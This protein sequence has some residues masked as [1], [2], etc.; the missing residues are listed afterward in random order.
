MCEAPLIKEEAHICIHCK[1]TL[2]RTMSHM[3]MDNS[4][5]KRFWGKIPLK[6]AWAYLKFTKQGKVQ[7]VLHKLKYG[8]YQEVGEKLGR[9]YAAELKEGGFDKEFD[10]IIPVPL[11]ISKLKK[12]G[13][14]QS[15][16]F[17]K[18][19]SEE[20]KIE[21]NQKVLI[22]NTASDTQ[23]KKKRLERWENVEKVFSVMDKD[24]ITG[25]RILLVDDVVTTGSTLEA[26]AQ[27]LIDN[28]CKE[29]SIA[30]IASAQ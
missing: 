19:L 26:C 14:N 20:M 5:A 23:T 9:W 15:D 13:Y 22:K 16:T 28:G 17:A 18:G 7:R 1:Y 30:A 6:Y 4:L 25:K 10:L 27:V 24:M 2:P 12:R 3:E 8:G 29:I 11:H 21:W